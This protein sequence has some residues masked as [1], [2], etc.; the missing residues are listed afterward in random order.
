MRK[1][2]RSTN[3]RMN[4]TFSQRLHRVKDEEQHEDLAKT[5]LGV[6]QRFHQYE[7]EMVMKF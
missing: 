1:R 7:K 5:A 3:E 4:I 2:A 6:N